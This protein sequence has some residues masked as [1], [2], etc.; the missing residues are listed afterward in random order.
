[1]DPV[2]LFFHIYYDTVPECLHYTLLPSGHSIYMYKVFPIHDN[3]DIR[4][5]YQNGTLLVGDHLHFIIFRMLVHTHE[6]S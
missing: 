1:M 3:I 6:H 2:F 4:P 5:V